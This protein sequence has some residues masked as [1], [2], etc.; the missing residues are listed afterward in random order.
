M[1]GCKVTFCIE[2]PP[3]TALLFAHH[4]QAAQ[5]MCKYVYFLNWTLSDV[6]EQFAMLRL[7]AAV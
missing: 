2:S 1:E 4:L 3:A 6:E 7:H 5:Q